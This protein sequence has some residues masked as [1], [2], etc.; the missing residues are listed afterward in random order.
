MSGKGVN[1]TD[2]VTQTFLVGLLIVPARI[3]SQGLTFVSARTADVVKSGSFIN[4]AGF[5]WKGC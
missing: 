3:V 2:P 5:R 1:N 4:Q